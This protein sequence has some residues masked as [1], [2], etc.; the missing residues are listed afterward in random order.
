ML[1]SLKIQGFKFAHEK[2]LESLILQNIV[3]HVL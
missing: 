2:R 1:N 3:L